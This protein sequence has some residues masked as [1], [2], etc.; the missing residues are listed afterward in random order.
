MVDVVWTIEQDEFIRSCRADG[1]SYYDIAAKLC[2]TANQVIG[3]AHRL[4]VPKG[5]HVIAE[6]KRANEAKRELTVELVEAIV[7]PPAPRR[8]WRPKAYGPPAKCEWIDGD[9]HRERI[10]RGEDPHCGERVVR[11]SFC[12]GHAERAYREPPPLKPRHA[13]SRER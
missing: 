4:G 12:A 10:A 7:A 6:G 2:R 9:D 1:L 8:E 11:G 3:R 13:R 5:E